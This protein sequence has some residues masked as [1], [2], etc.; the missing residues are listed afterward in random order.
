M[1]TE[2][3]KKK[4]CKALKI[5]TKSMTPTII[6]NKIGEIIEFNEAMERLTGYKS[7]DLDNNIHN[8]LEKIIPV[9]DLR[10]SIIKKDSNG[11]IIDIISEEIDIKSMN[12]NNIHVKLSLHNFDDDCF[13]EPLQIIQAKNL[14]SKK[15]YEEELLQ[16]QQRY[17]MVV[18]SQTEII[19]RF[20]PDGTITFVNK[21]YR[22]FFNKEESELLGRKLFQHV[23]EKERHVL[24]NHLKSLTREDPTG[25]IE[26]EI[27]IDGK[28]RWLEWNNKAIFDIKGN[29]VEYQSVGRDVTDN[30]TTETQLKEKESKYRALFER[31]NDGILLI[32]LDGTIIEANH[33][34]C[35]MFD[36][37]KEELIGMNM[38]KLVHPEEVPDSKHKIEKLLD[39]SSHEI[40]E[41]TFLT[42]NENKIFTEMNV[43]LVYNP[44]GQPNHI[45]IIARDISTRKRQEEELNHYRNQ[46][47]RMVEIRTNALKKIN[48][49]LK[50]QIEER[51]KTEEDL[52]NRNNFIQTILD[53]L[54]IGLAVNCM[55]SKEI[56]YLNREFVNIHGW[57]E[58]EIKEIPTDI[59]KAVVNGKKGNINGDNVNRTLNSIA[60][61]FVSNGD[62]KNIK[63]TTRAGEQRY[64]LT[65]KIPVEEENLIISTFQ[66][67]T[68]K[69]L[70]EERIK[71]SLK[72]K[73]LLLKEVH[74]RV[75]NNLQLLTSMLR[76]QR[77]VIVDDNTLYTINQLSNRIMTLSLIYENLYLN[78]NLET[79]DI[80]QCI[81]SIITNLLSSNGGLSK[82]IKRD[83]Q[84]ENIY[85]NIDIAIPCGLLVNEIVSNSIKYA[86]MDGRKGTIKVEFHQE[87]D[88][89]TLIISDDGVGM[90]SGTDLDNYNTMGLK[91]INLLSKKL[92]ADISLDKRNG[93]TYQ[94]TFKKSHFF[95]D[96]II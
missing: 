7:L 12:D 42:K 75:K 38:E 71:L 23:P 22:D 82:D 6:I 95:N 4:D 47:E 73:D 17:R 79:I 91:M 61:S 37:N 14:T 19:C 13:I 93:T 21:T 74:H 59:F 66:N 77:A 28:M 84:I 46:L 69:K 87:D 39:G 64:V 26:H 86:F 63:I 25:K 65:K 1:E 11:H 32:K 55:D 78:R 92:K 20:R 53:S 50:A 48:E 49:K 2:D 90:P 57:S 27:M 45:Q 41:R 5:I 76:L 96:L 43:A 33:K 10:K 40:Y 35:F 24:N 52:I 3:N 51:K 8:F 72:E 29:L 30:K 16:S 15:Y 9:S 60:D 88:T 68:E 81:K 94:V 54:P 80:A 62:W 58:N 89:H 85:L 56:K 83:I 67:I 18:E 70:A 44:D 34:A 36:Y 31:N